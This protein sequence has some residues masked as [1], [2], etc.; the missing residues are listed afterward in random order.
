[1]KS[2]RANVALAIV[3][4]A[5][6]GISLPVIFGEPRKVDDQHGGD[7]W[8]NAI[9]DFQTLITGVAAVAAAYFA[10]NQS[11]VVEANSERRHQQLME[12]SL[13]PARLMIDRT[14]FPMVEYIEDA[15]EDIKGWHQ[16]VA[17]ESGAW[18]VAQNLPDLKKM[19]DSWNEIVFDEQ[20]GIA[21]AY[22]DGEMVH[23]LRLSREVAKTLLRNVLNL[24]MQMSPL[25]GYVGEEE[26]ITD[27]LREPVKQIELRLATLEEFLSKFD[28][29][30]RKLERDYLK[31]V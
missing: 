9:Y 12:L 14:V 1:M 6:V 26:E 21:E 3:V 13:R 29:G 16:R 28:D 8:R 24:E 11:R 4:A 22:F 31:S 15:L 10:I 19:A 20:L 5:T 23:A 18:F 2:N 27:V 25:T 30:L 17:V 7:A